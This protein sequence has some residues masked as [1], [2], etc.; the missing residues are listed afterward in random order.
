ML[1]GIEGGKGLTLTYKTVEEAARS[2]RRTIEEETGRKSEVTFHFAGISESGGFG[3]ARIS[4]HEGFEPAF[5]VPSNG[6]VTW[7]LSRAEFSPAEWLSG[8]IACLTK[9]EPS[10]LQKLAVDLVKLT[11][12]NDRYVSNVFDMLTLQ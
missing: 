9:V 4:H 12:A 8:R 3:L 1:W 11:A 2:F 10:E 6:G 5:M 7:S